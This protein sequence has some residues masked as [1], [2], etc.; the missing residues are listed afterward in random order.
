MK[1]LSDVCTVH[2]YWLQHHNSMLVHSAF[3]RFKQKHCVWKP[4]KTL[5]CCICC[6]WSMAK[7][8][9][10]AVP[11]GSEAGQVVR[12]SVCGFVQ[13]SLSRLC[14]QLP[15]TELRYRCDQRF[16]IANHL[17]L[18]CLN[19]VGNGWKQPKNPWSK[20][21]Q[22]KHSRVHFRGFPKWLP[23]HLPQLKPF[24]TNASETPGH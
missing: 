10:P 22:N 4:A 20:H 11:A 18:R 21:V 23:Q 24:Q 17:T 12:S 3:S 7:S 15:G 16:L 5:F 2:E 13:R 19:P 8:T 6:R 1:T 14:L 9:L